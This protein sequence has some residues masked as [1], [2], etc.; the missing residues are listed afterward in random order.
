MEYNWISPSGIYCFTNKING[1]RY[2]GLSTNLRSR[3]RGHIR[4]MYCYKK[5]GQYDSSLLHRDMYRFGIDNFT[6][7]VLE[8]TDNQ[9][10]DNQERYWIQKYSTLWPNGYNK[11]KGGRDCASYRKIS[12]AD[13]KAIQQDLLDGKTQWFIAH[14]FHVD[15]GTISHIN[16]GKQW[17]DANLSYPLFSMENRYHTQQRQKSLALIKKIRLVKQQNSDKKEKIALQQLILQHPQK[18]GLV[19][20]LAVRTHKSTHWV[21][22]HLKKIW[23]D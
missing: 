7:E 11:Q 14:K 2:I 21:G 12:E 16:N 19:S 15:Q 3:Y 1:K 5:S 6:Y 17:P 8:Y 20:F 9:H 18:Y 23:F 4:A 10:L 22:D 13:V